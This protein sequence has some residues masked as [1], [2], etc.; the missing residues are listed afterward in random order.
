LTIDEAL[1]AAD[2]PLG[3]FVACALSGLVWPVPEDVAVLY[4]GVRV[5]SGEWPLVGTTVAAIVGVMLRDVVAWGIGRLAGEL[6]LDR[7]WVIRRVGADRLARARALVDRHG[8]RAVLVGR[9]LIGMRAPIFAVAGAG[10]VPL[11][12]FLAWDLLGAVFVVPAGLAIGA[13]LGPA[14]VDAA[15]PLVRQARVLVA[16]AVVVGAA[17]WWMRWRRGES[18]RRGPSDGD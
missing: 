17:L 9:F 14:L 18:A 15:L 2:G 4:A 1:G 13:A 8:S 11:G 10:G 7:P 6:L 3:L 12:A 16:V 5:A